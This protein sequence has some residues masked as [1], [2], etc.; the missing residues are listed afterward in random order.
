MGGLYLLQRKFG[1]GGNLWGGFICGGGF[2]IPVGKTKNLAE[3]S[4]V[5][6][7]KSPKASVRMTNRRRKDA[8]NRSKRSIIT[9]YSVNTS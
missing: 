1:G 6:A 9:C 3:N 5:F 8:C 4:T 2:I 7:V